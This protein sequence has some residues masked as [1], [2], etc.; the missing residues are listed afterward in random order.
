MRP[1]R[2][3]LAA[4]VLLLATLIVPGAASADTTRTHQLRMVG[5]SDLQ[6]AGEVF[7][8]R[9]LDDWGYNRNVLYEGSVTPEYIGICLWSSARFTL[10]DRDGSTLTAEL[11]RTQPRHC[12]SLVSEYRSGYVVV[13]GGTGRFEGAEGGGHVELQGLAADLSGTLVLTLSD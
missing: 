8:G 5:I 2:L 12:F 10:I 9:A 7:A 4:A 3:V 1:L 6:V 11:D 13:T